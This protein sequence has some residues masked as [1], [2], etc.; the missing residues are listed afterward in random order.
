[1]LKYCS[2]DNDNKHNNPYIMAMTNDGT[3]VFIC[4]VYY[5]F[6]YHAL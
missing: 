3:Q 5:N 2:F 4:K 1:M 6:W